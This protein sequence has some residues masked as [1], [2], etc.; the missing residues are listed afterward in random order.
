M[1]LHL[2]DGHDTEG[3]PRKL[4]ALLEQNGFIVQVVK[5]DY[6][7]RDIV[8]KT[9]GTRVRVCAKIPIPIKFYNQLLKTKH[10]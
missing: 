3:N 10:V 9:W 1:A 8:N 5:E 6:D 7:G 2:D 4:F